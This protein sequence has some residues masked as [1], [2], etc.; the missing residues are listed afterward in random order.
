[1]WQPQRLLRIV[2]IGSGVMSLADDQFVLFF[3]L[4]RFVSCLPLEQLDDLA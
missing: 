4:F 3:V 1:M 2:E